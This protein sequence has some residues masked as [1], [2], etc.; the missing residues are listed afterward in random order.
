LTLKKAIDGQC[1]NLCSGTENYKFTS[2]DGTEC[3]PSC[4]YYETLESG[5][6]QC[7]ESCLDSENEKTFT[8][9]DQCVLQADCPAKYI[10]TS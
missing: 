7:L 2:V 5:E 3:L 9:D 8:L 6:F 4:Q 10:E 1:V